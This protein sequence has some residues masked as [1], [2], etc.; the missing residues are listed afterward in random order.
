MPVGE[1]NLG[2]GG[3]TGQSFDS[4][5]VATLWAKVDALGPNGSATMPSCTN[6]DS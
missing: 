1:M 2:T 4:A 6:L 5:N 3:K